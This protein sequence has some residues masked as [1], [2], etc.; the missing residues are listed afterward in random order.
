[1]AELVWSKPGLLILA[2]R[3]SSQ[4][5]RGW[6]Q[7]QESAFPERKSGAGPHGKSILGHFSNF[8]RSNFLAWKME[9]CTYILEVTTVKGRKDGTS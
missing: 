3:H 6:S 2:N 4:R 9:V 5:L 8:S 7:P 1:M